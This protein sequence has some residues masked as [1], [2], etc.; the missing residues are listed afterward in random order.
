MEMHVNAF[1]RKLVGECVAHQE[2]MLPNAL[3]A[4]QLPPTSASE[5]ATRKAAFVQLP[6]NE[7]EAVR[8]N[9]R[10][11]LALCF[12]GLAATSAYVLHWLL[13]ERL[14]RRFG[15]TVVRRPR[16]TVARGG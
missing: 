11:L 1:T 4:A 6:E 14:H 7:N 10:G 16:P 5:R 12:V 9:H 15:E 13:S 2:S 8:G 3:Q